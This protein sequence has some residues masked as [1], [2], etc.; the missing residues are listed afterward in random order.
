MKTP[1]ACLLLAIVPAAAAPVEHVV[2]PEGIY[3]T[4]PFSFTIDYGI[5]RLATSAVDPEPD[6]LKI[7]RTTV[8]WAYMR[9]WAVY[10]RDT[11]I[12]EWDATAERD[13]LDAIGHPGPQS[14]QWY[15]GKVQ[16]DARS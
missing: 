13:Y 1:I 5:K 9:G 2:C 3:H 12:L 8:E 4:A 15:R 14:R 6:T 16:C 10:R 11:H 7:T